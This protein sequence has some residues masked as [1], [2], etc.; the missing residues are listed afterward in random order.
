MSLY[1][2]SVVCYAL[3]ELWSVVRYCVILLAILG[4]AT[5]INCAIGCWDIGHG[6]PVDRYNGPLANNYI[7]GWDD[8][9]YDGY[10]G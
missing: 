5:I 10:D 8:S 1:A 3:A 2:M 9:T 7:G 6:N 4:A